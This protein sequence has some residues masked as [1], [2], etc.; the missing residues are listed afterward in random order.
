MPDLRA[1]E[2]KII[3]V[4]GLIGLTI[5]ITTILIVPALDLGTFT[6]FVYSILV[7]SPMAWFGF[8]SP[9]IFLDGDDLIVQ[10]RNR[11]VSRFLISGVTSVRVSPALFHFN[12]LSVRH[13]S[14]VVLST[15]VRES[16]LGWI[17]AQMPVESITP[18]WRRRILETKNRLTRRSIQRR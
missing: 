1:N 16:D 6:M 7:L 5:L 12:M 3:G 15:Y 4:V 17:I 8:R 9:R 18:Y 13:S 14:G 2:S 10:K 11:G